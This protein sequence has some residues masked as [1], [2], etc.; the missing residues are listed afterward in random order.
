MKC[1]NLFCLLILLS[2][3]LSLSCEIPQETAEYLIPEKAIGAFRV[4]FTRI[5]FV[6]EASPFGVPMETVATLL[7]DWFAKMG[8]EVA[9]IREIQGFFLP[10]NEYQEQTPVAAVVNLSAYDPVAFNNFTVRNPE[11][12]EVNYKQSTYWYSE[13]DRIA[14][15]DVSDREIIVANEISAMDEMIELAGRE[16][17]L[18]AN[19]ELTGFLRKNSDKLVAVKAE[20]T[21]LIP[22]DLWIIRNFEA[23]GF[24]LDIGSTLETKIEIDTADAD[25]ADGI[26]ALIDGTAKTTYGLLKLGLAVPEQF[27]EQYTEFTP[28]V[29][30]AFVTINEIFGS[31][32]S[33]ARNSQ[34][35]IKMAPKIGLVIKMLGYASVL[36]GFLSSQ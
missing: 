35:T 7:K 1:N 8:I 21:D 16:I 17:P 11:M 34:V 10:Y 6:D 2:V 30:E 3:L 28:D 15:Y 20:L 31:L 24:T 14:V 32:E 22:G 13:T 36:D 29:R 4:D 19:A 12:G 33:R 27:E 5:P 26:A 23:V 25:T 9:D 18:A